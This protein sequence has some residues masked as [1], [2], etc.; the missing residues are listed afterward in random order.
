[1]VLSTSPILHMFANC[2]KRCMASNKPLELG[3]R[4][5]GLP[6]LTM[7]FNLLVQTLLSSSFTLHLIFSFYLYTWMI[8]WSLVVVPRWFLT[9]S[10]TSA[11]SLHFG[12]LDLCHIF[13]VFKLTN[14]APSCILLSINILL[15]FSNALR[16]RL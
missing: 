9:S 1:M 10:P 15:I 13:W 11:L 5:F 3:F 7:V 2:T 6:C 14:L 16:W 4:S 12:I 8:S